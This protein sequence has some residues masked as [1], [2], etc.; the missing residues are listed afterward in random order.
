METEEIFRIILPILI[1]AF[2][3]HRG[4]YTKKSVRPENDT[5]KKRE[6][7]LLSKFAGLLGMIGF[8]SMIVYVIN[9]AWLAWANA[10]FPLWLRWLGVGVALL[11][12]ALLQWAQVTLGKSWSDTPRMMKEQ[13]LITSGPYQFI[14][15]PI[16]TA[17]LSILGST[18]WISS[19]W[20]I[21]LCWAG[22]TILEVASRVGFE[23][24]LMLEYFGEQYREYM[25]KTGRLLPHL[26]P[27]PRTAAR[28]P[29]RAK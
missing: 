24:S 11:G 7:G 1:V 27:P 28:T 5:L 13:A 12:F 26:L 23:E 18:L 17:F 16:Y 4:Y 2:I 9:P 21:G 25:K 15:H 14:R 8:I 22:M 6:E 10:G 29:P 20:L 19:N 3:A